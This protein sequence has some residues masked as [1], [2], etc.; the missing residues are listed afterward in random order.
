M[1][2]NNNIQ[3]DYLPNKGFNYNDDSC[4]KKIPPTINPNLFQNDPKRHNSIYTGYT[5]VPKIQDDGTKLVNKLI[6][7]DGVPR[8]QNTEYGTK[9]TNVRYTTPITKNVSLFEN[10]LFQ[11]NDPIQN[12][13]GSNT[14]NTIPPLRTQQSSNNWNSIK[15]NVPYLRSE[16]YQ[17]IDQVN[18]QYLENNG[19]DSYNIPSEETLLKLSNYFQQNISNNLLEISPFMSLVGFI[20][21]KTNFKQKV[22][23][24]LF[25][26]DIIPQTKTIN[27]GNV[28]NVYYP[29]NVFNN[30][31]FLNK[32]G[33]MYIDAVPLFS[34]N[35]VL[36][37]V[38][39][40]KKNKSIFIRD[41]EQH[42]NFQSLIRK[43]YTADTLTDLVIQLVRRA[44]NTVLNKQQIL[45]YIQRYISGDRNTSADNI[46]QEIRNLNR[47]GTGTKPPENIDEAR[48]FYEKRQGVIENNNFIVSKDGRFIRYIE[49]IQDG[50]LIYTN[51]NE[52]RNTQRE[53]SS[54][55]P[56]VLYTSQNAEQNRQSKL[57]NEFDTSMENRKLI[58][59][60]LFQEQ[61]EGI[62][63]I[64]LSAIPESPFRTTRDD[65][66]GQEQPTSS[67]DLTQQ[68]L[69]EASEE[70]QGEEEPT[71]EAS[72]SG[73]EQD[74]N[75][76]LN[77]YFSLNFEVFTENEPMK[78]YKIQI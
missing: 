41:F 22:N 19:L 43:Y 20:D 17:S 56:I 50:N 38:I 5:Y 33:M 51:R 57:L 37:L 14:Q 64:D 23:K 28:N 67:T 3:S 58:Y 31:D 59:E 8:L 54:Y 69:Q 61:Q 70:V 6:R 29:Q 74:Y 2:R 53:F 78:I 40:G 44:R 9:K 52:Q 24:K 62:G 35:R 46:T 66:T 21:N 42:E 30:D 18:Q 34:L 76:F 25:F 4:R 12:R 49:N 71:S 39:E 73:F 55:R 47:T 48:I 60:K 72:G 75:D 68:F 16:Y 65:D 27:Q 63:K 15:N 1:I 11:V 32:L 10:P 45:P 26:Y 36:K 7:E 13:F 77:R